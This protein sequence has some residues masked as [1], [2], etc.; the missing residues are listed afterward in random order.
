MKPVRWGVISTANIGMEKV[1]PGMMKSAGIEI[2]AISS[3]KLKQAQAAAAKLGIPKAYGSTKNTSRP[4]LKPSITAAQS[5]ACAVNPRRSQSGKHVLCEKPVAMSAKEAVSSQNSRAFM[6]RKR[7]YAQPAV[8][9]QGHEGRHRRLCAPCRST[10]LLQRDPRNV[11]N[12][13]DIGGG[14]LYDIGCTP[15]QHRAS[16]LAPNWRVIATLTGIPNSR[17]IGW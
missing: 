10:S 7:W 6:W 12:M 11:R 1:L 4:R 2:V 9:G 14:G 3:R 16:C 13:A 17:P 5:S 15:S 8:A